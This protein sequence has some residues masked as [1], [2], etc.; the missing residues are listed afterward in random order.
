MVNIL[1]KG[2]E[3]LNKLDLAQQKIHKETRP[4]N[5]VTVL[6]GGDFE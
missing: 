6:P 1:G 5:D 2:A 3:I 4:D